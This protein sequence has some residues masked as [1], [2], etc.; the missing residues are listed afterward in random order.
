LLCSGESREDFIEE[1]IDRLSIW[2][3][4]AEAGDARGQMLYGLCFL[5][6]Q[7][8]EQS[9]EVAVDWFQK[10]A[11]QGNAQSQCSLGLCHQYGWGVEEN[12]EVAVDWF[13]K[14]A[15]QGN[16]RAEC[17]LGMCYSN[18][19]GV[20]ENK[21]IANEWFKK[22]AA[23]GNP[24]AIKQMP[25]VLTKEIAEQFLADEDSV[26]LSEFTAIEDDAAER[27][28]ELEVF[29]LHLDGLTSLS[30]A[31]AESLSKHKGDYLE[32]NGLTSLSDAAAES[33]SE[34][35]GTLELNGLTTLSDAA[36]GSLSEHQNGAS[37]GRD[38]A[39]L[40]LGGLTSLSGNAAEALSKHR[41]LS[42][43][44]SY[45]L[46]SEAAFKLTVGDGGNVWLKSVDDIPQ[47]VRF[48][49]LLTN[50][51]VLKLGGQDDEL[52]SE[53]IDSLSA[54][55]CTI[56]LSPLGEIN[57]KLAEKLA[58]FNASSLDLRECE[59]LSNEA[60]ELLLKFNGSLKIKLCSQDECTRKTLKTHHSLANWGEVN[61]PY[62]DQV[63][64]NCG[65][66]D[67]L[68]FPD[69]EDTIYALFGDGPW[70]ICWDCR[71]E[72]TDEQIASLE[73]E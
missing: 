73:E 7:G 2:K 47:F 41:T 16:A 9:K 6:G 12:N 32:L 31:A 56:D 50:N 68:E 71:E 61:G 30:D 34:H 60:A 55:E 17:S 62:V 63:C 13:Q 21:S 38:G 14:S 67:R 44:G 43:E 8:V 23:Q 26:D 72:L 65:F 4:S 27:L 10:S 28:S 39:V 1:N 35:K 3:D 69:S 5:Y 18:G 25:K 36:A 48:K 15:D 54:L 24:R 40:S 66:E 45:I 29:R 64:K 19:W 46:T 42:I 51:H 70:D 52:T 11:D 33:L 53:H 49:D 22:S 37:Q 58:S 57:E 20:E 59:L